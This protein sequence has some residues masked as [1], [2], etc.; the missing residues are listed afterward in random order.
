MIIYLIRHGQVDGS[1]TVFN[2][3]KK[4]NDP[5]LSEL[6]RWQAET[7]G[8]RLQKYSIT[9][10]FTS[11][12][13]RAVE[14]TQIISRYLH[15]EIYVTEDLRE[16]NSKQLELEIVQAEIDINKP[17]ELIPLEIRRIRYF[18]DVLFNEDNNVA[19]V[20]HSALIQWLLSTLLEIPFKNRSLIGPIIECGITQLSFHNGNYQVRSMN[21]YSHLE[22]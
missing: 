19:I 10:L 4:C 18:L 9:K 13:K 15:C 16:V 14:T 1:T 6:G 3:E 22:F 17:R 11:D 21:D 8:K 5:V 7:L 2:E 12:L 20:T